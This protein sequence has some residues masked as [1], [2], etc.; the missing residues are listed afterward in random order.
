MT[1][2]MNKNFND[3][4][5]RFQFWVNE[6]GPL[7]AKAAHDRRVKEQLPKWTLTDEARLRLEQSFAAEGVDLAKAKLEWEARQ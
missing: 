3:T 4:P 6:L 1:C 7:L 5:P 2:T